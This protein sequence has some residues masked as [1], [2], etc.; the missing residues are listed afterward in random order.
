[1]K[2]LLRINL[3]STTYQLEPI[4]NQYAKLGGRGLSSKIISEE[5]PPKCDPLGNENKIVLAPG[6]L[7]GTKMPCSGRLSIGTKSPL[8]N[9]IKEANAG[10]KVSRQL[11][12]LG[13]HCVIIE[14]Y[15]NELTT[16]KVDHK[17]VKFE[18]AK[19]LAGIGNYECFETLKDSFGP[20]TGIISIGPAGEMKLKAAA[21]A[22]STSDFHIRIAARGGVG[23]VMG[24]KNLKAI[25]VND[26]EGEGFEI[27]DKKNLNEAAKALSKGI[28]THPL[29][30]A[31]KDLG[32]PV[33]VNMVNGM[34]ALP[35]K[36]FSQGKFEKA[37]Q[38]SGEFLA[39]LT[40][41]RPNA[42]ASHACM[43][44]CVIQC[45]NIL[46]DEK[47]DL[48]CGSIEFETLALI[49]S[50][51]MI[52]DIE[53]VARLNHACNDI[54]LDT[55]DVGGALAVAMEAGLIPWGDAEAALSLVEGIKKGAADSKMI[56]NGTQF[57]GEK[58]GVKRI[59]VV[60]GQC[61]S[62]YDPRALKG[63]G[64][65]YATSPMGADHTC[66][67]ALPSPT[68][69]DYNPQAAT[70]QAPV[71]KFLQ[72]Y[73]AAIDSLGLCLFLSLPILDIPDL[74]MH[75][76]DAA[77][78][79]LGESLDEDYVEQLG[80]SVLQTERG[81]N[82]EVGFTK[83]DDRLPRFFTEETLTSIDTNFD[84]SDEELDSVY[85]E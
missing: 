65:T 58:L 38:L 56:G 84:V 21:I 11:A 49:G 23:S 53:K 62:G 18:S 13:I 33:L 74:K 64:V 6:L 68:Q 51:C 61:L 30:G 2:K 50:N 16:I 45:S 14:G 67:N 59:P 69:P 7:A 44:G 43:S 77:S 3:D 72:G 82:L 48:I 46:T 29:M 70:G 12:N 73:F 54:G 9:T 55:M 31:L 26:S 60:K 79:I 81:F 42:K 39:G 71:S 1:M 4:P 17:G 63:T 8:T 47:G 40:N 85:S 10:G 41:S 76:I 57:T 28:A 36:N 22:V 34:G 35:T 25:V 15:A 27:K 75:V 83:D 32:T 78:A 24:A 66:G 19:S 80:A 5:V 37:E 20:E 52:D